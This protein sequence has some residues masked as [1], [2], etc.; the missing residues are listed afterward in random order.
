MSHET[1]IS[2]QNNKQHLTLHT[3]IP[4]AIPTLVSLCVSKLFY[5]IIY[6]LFYLLYMH[7]GLCVHTCDVKHVRGWVICAHA[8]L[9]ASKHLPLPFPT[10]FIWDKV[11]YWT[12]SI[13][14][15]QQA[16]P[17][18]HLPPPPQYRSCMWAQS[19]PSF[20]VGSGDGTQFLM[21][22]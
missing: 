17:V 11:C 15:F 9:E 18:S 10:L 2:S 5:I 22:M 12:L 14:E 20:W 19:H 13:D 6:Y 4:P 7:A 21:H 1:R 3:Q 8:C 16:P